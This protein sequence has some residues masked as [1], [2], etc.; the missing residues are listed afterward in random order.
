MYMIKEEINTSE[1]WQKQFPNPKVLD[2]DGWDRKNYQY[3]WFEEKITFVEYSMRLYKSTVSFIQNDSNLNLQQLEKNLDNSLATETS[4][5]LSNWLNDKRKSIEEY[6]Y[7]LQKLVNE[8]YG[9][10]VI[11]KSDMTWEL[12]LEEKV[13]LY[14]E[15]YARQMW[16]EYYDNEYDTGMDLT[17]GEVCK[18]DF[19]AGVEYQKQQNKKLYGEEEILEHLNH[20]VRMPSSKL[21]LYTDDSEGITI[22]W[23]EQFKKKINYENIHKNLHI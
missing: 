7:P 19:L 5:S 14:A 3:S 12:K 13:E 6:N 4:E 1:E 23:F 20:L 2:P 16:R 18:K 22:K 8:G 17:Y 10:N 9:N 21:D 11:L 15:N